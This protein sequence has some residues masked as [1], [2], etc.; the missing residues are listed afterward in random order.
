MSNHLVTYSDTHIFHHTLP[1]LPM[2]IPLYT[3]FRDSCHFAKSLPYKGWGIPCQG[4]CSAIMQKSI[5]RARQISR[6][7]KCETRW[8]KSHSPPWWMRQFCRSSQKN[9]ARCR[10]FR[11]EMNW[12]NFI[13]PSMKND[14]GLPLWSDWQGVLDLYGGETK[15]LRNVGCVL[16]FTGHVS[17]SHLYIFMFC[18][19]IIWK[20]L[21]MNRKT[22]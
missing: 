17:E 3:S 9:I 2:T 6:A 13:G 12:I 16:T 18:T 21:N 11:C 7:S 20:M 14:H 8:Q 5:L 10:L 15:L 1:I 4:W 19:L 22:Y